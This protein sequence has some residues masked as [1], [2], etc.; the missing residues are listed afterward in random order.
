MRDQYF[1]V[2]PAGI[3]QAEAKNDIAT[4]I[5][6]QGAIKFNGGGALMIGGVCWCLTGGG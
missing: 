1:V 4:M 3:S 2:G 6:L 5:K